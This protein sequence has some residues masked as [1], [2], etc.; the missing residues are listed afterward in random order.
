MYSKE[1]VPEPTTLGR[2][3]KKSSDVRGDI[4]IKRVLYAAAAGRRKKN[5]TET[6]NEDKK[7][8]RISIVVN[9]SA[10]IRTTSSSEVGTKCNGFFCL[11]SRAFGFT[12]CYSSSPTVWGF[13]PL[14]R[15]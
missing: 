3:L 11:L 13:S 7:Q 1:N 2:S 5:Q 14:G 12:P 8:H 4:K 10:R 15:S 9:V 6:S